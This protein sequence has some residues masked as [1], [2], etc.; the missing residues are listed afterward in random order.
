M[1]GIRKLDRC[2]KNPSL[3]K[4]YGNTRF[5]Y[6]IPN[7]NKNYVKLDEESIFWFWSPKDGPRPTSVQFKALIV[8]ETGNVA[9]P[10]EFWA[11]IDSPVINVMKAAE[12]KTSYSLGNETYHCYKEKVTEDSRRR[13]YISSRMNINMNRQFLSSV[14][15]YTEESSTVDP[16]TSSHADHSESSVGES[17]SSELTT[18]LT[19]ATSVTKPNLVKLN[20]ICK[21]VKFDII[22]KGKPQTKPPP[23][24]LHIYEIEGDSNVNTLS[25]LVKRNTSFT[26]E[27]LVV[28][29][30][31]EDEVPTGH[32]IHQPCPDYRQKTQGRRHV[33]AFC[34]EESASP[35]KHG[36]YTKRRVKLPAIDIPDEINLVKTILP[37]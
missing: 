12:L 3:I 1:A 17:S 13:F 23:V 5:V 37:F 20:A 34:P 15:S 33:S 11:G 36:H 10:K 28:L 29:A 16:G 32:F 19:P 27:Y 7:K 2:I 8:R 31:N 21:G 26:F 24:R 25:L 6:I 9:K 30:L 4:K 22:G 35:R 18:G 14:E